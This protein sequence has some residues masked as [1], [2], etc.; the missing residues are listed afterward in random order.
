MPNEI[1]RMRGLVGSLFAWLAKR[2][3]LL[4]SVLALFGGFALIFAAVIPDITVNGSTTLRGT[5]AAFSGRNESF[6][7]PSGLSELRL[8]NASCS[9]SITV[10][11]EAQLAEHQTRGIRPSAQLDCEQPLATFTYPLR[12][13]I[14]ENGGASSTAY[15]VAA[16]FLDVR[17]SRGLLSLL[18]IPLVALGASYL[19]RQG[20]HRSIEKM[21]H[22]VEAR[23]PDKKR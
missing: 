21:L 9:V 4:L 17:Y 6:Q 14:I 3:N 13:I 23:R 10:L 16:R 15:E 7:T 5:L 1:D 8:V 19:I 20:F 12:W 2:R 11:N 22:E 18:A